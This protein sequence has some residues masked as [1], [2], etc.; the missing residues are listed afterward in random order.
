LKIF[1]LTHCVFPMCRWASEKA[2]Q[3][4]VAGIEIQRN[5][6]SKK[7]CTGHRSVRYVIANWQQGVFQLLQL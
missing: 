5:E 3:S 4:A 2:T 7:A 1:P 6:E